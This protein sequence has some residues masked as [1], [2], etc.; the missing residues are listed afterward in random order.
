MAVNNYETWRSDW[1]KR[2]CSMDKKK[3][4]AKLPFLSM[5]AHFLFVPYLKKTCKIRLSDGVIEPSDLSLYD[6]LNIFTL[7]WYAKEHASLTGEFCAFRYL[8]DASPFDAAFEKNNLRAFAET[9]SG[10]KEKLESVL[11]SLGGRKLPVGD[12]AY[13][14]D[15]FPCIPMQ[16]IF[17][18][19]DEEFPAQCNLL[20]DRSATD[21]IHVESIVTIASET[22]RHLANAA[23]LPL[24]GTPF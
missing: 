13:Q 19:A 4:L 14:I 17:W 11:K 24:R 8:K 18:D 16:V 6:Y 7:F 10:Q 3:L 2:F 15:V 1:Q 20:F 12:I 22:L 21:F 23:Q 5:D 9:F